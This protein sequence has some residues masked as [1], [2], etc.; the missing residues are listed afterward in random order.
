MNSGTDLGQSTTKAHISTSI[1]YTY[2][3]QYL[4]SIKSIFHEI[5]KSMMTFKY[6]VMNM[7]V[8]IKSDN[9][10]SMKQAE[11]LKSCEG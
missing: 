7:I 9:I 11:K 10:C 1:W 8:G 6:W 2:L 3:Y 4:L 5:E